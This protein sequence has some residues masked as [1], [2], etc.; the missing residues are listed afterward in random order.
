[1]E[2]RAGGMGGWGWGVLREEAERPRE[3][4]LQGL[5]TCRLHIS[6]LQSSLI[7]PCWVTEALPFSPRACPS[8][9]RLCVPAQACSRTQV[10]VLEGACLFVHVPA[11]KYVH[12]CAQP[13]W[14]RRG[15]RS[16]D[17]EGF[18]APLPLS[19]SLSLPLFLA[20][21]QETL[22]KLQHASR[23]SPQI[24]QRQ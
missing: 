10:C 18:S 3:A 12:M 9:R 13:C 7:A 20:L 2:V 23:R 1:M 16:C 19:L 4:A 5:L 21:Q 22:I 6:E 11:C 24:Q 14:Q 8:V 17:G 15:M